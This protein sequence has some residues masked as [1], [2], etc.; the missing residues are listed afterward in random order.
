M[1]PTCE[2]GGGTHG[3]SNLPSVPPI[4]RGPLRRA[5]RATISGSNRRK[6]SLAAMLT[7]A[8][9]GSDGRRRPSRRGSARRP[10]S[11]T[12]VEIAARRERMLRVAGCL[13]EC[14]AQR[15]AKGKV[16]ETPELHLFRLGSIHCPGR[17]LPFCNAVGQGV[18][19]FFAAACPLV[20]A[21]SRAA[22]RQRSC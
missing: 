18:A 22:P 12:H 4:P 11:R 7:A 1:C 16:Q 9:R 3:R 15:D 8:A 17:G 6:G 13:N 5:L 19:P 20:V 2:G 14:H 21:S 10:M